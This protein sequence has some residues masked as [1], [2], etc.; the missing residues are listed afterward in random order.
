MSKSIQSRIAKALKQVICEVLDTHLAMHNSLYD[1]EIYVLGH[2]AQS[3][4]S[5]MNKRFR[6]LLRS[7][8]YRGK[9]LE[10]FMNLEVLGV[11]VFRFFDEE[12]KIYFNDDD[13]YDLIMGDHEWT[14]KYKSLMLESD[15]SEALST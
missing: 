8:P 5:L 10:A 2:L 9:K 3:I 7:I 11:K 15:E 1:E 4:T 6:K 12:K 13:L 14:Q